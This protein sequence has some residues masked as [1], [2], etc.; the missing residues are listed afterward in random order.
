MG[1]AKRE[2]VSA[3][4]PYSPALLECFCGGGEEGTVKIALLKP[5]ETAVA[6]LRREK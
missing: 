2:E 4:V 1:T 5:K 6:R 3:S